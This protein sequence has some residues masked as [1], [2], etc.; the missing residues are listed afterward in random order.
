MSARHTARARLLSKDNRNHLQDQGITN[1]TLPFGAWKLNLYVVYCL[2]KDDD[3]VN[4]LQ[5]PE[6]LRHALQ[7]EL[8]SYTAKRLGAAAAALSTRYRTTGQPGE[9]FV[10]TPM[11]AAAYAAFRMPATFGAIYAASLE[12]RRRLP[13]WNPESMADIGA[14]PGTAS[15]AASAVWPTLKHFT[16]FE[17]APEM[18]AL[19]KRLFSH[20][21]H[22]DPGALQ[23]R[24]TDVE[25]LPAESFDLVVAGYVL[26]EIE[27]AKREA[28][29]RSLWQMAAGTLIL[30]EPGTPSGF[31]RIKEARERLIAAGAHT[32]A[33]CPG[34]VA[35]PLAEDDWC[36]FAQRIPRSPLH[37]HVKGGELGYEDEKFSYVV[38]SRLSV[39]TPVARV[40][41]HPQIRKG[42]VILDLCTPTGRMQ[43]TVARKSK[44]AYKEARTLRWGSESA[45]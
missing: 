33:P 22:F 24:A 10:R 19:G 1:P 15:W 4:R 42:H 28:I 17:R 37:R 26:G 18:I 30:V 13:D 23:W 41:R 16:L 5:L 35:C 34:N 9:R 32:M 2:Y 39:G 27:E 44:D 38:L 6:P 31:A 25:T 12:A 3:R 45:P 14:G 8:S 20:A 11:D 43:K 36:H 40:I 7:T 21:S 29:V